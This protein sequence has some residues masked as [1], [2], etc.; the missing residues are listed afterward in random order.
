MLIKVGNQI[1]NT[2]KIAHAVFENEGPHL[3]IS[4]TGSALTSLE[5]VAVIEG[6]EALPEWHA[7][8]QEAREVDLNSPGGLKKPW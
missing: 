4:F 5:G 3:L 8:L 6:E 1:I 2:E 7:L